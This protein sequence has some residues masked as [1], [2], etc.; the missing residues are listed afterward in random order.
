MSAIKPTH[1]GEI[2]TEEFLKPM[3][4]TPY[5]LAKDIGVPVNRITAIIKEQQGISPETALLLSRYFGVS[6]SLWLN[7]QEHYELERAK[8]ALG[9][10]LKTIPTCQA[11]YQASSCSGDIQVFK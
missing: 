10:K 8:D 2:L 6:N 5:C 9:E 1:P 11:G 4:I 7:L 3:G